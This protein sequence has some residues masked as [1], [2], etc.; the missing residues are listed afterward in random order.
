MRLISGAI[1]NSNVETIHEMSRLAEIVRSYEMVG[2]LLKSSSGY[3][4]GYGSYGFYPGYG[5]AG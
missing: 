5:Y 2:R 3:G 4:Y 1:E